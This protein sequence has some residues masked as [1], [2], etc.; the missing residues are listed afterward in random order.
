LIGYSPVTWRFVN[1]NEALARGIELSLKTTILKH[2]QWGLAYTYLKTLDVQYDRE[3]LRRPRHTVSSQLTYQSAAFDFF[4]E[5]VYVGKRLDYN[6]LVWSVADNPAFNTFSF[7]FNLPVS[8][9]FS[10]FLN[11]SNALN[12][13]FEEVLGYPAPLRRILVGIKY[14]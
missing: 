1:I 2:W 5:M 11:I 8:K 13:H 14:Q 12:R 9:K 4:V 3:L 10:W 6:E 7:V